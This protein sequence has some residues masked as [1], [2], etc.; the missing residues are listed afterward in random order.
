[1]FVQERQIAL[2]K[3]I[4]KLLYREVQ[5]LVGTS[6]ASSAAPEVCPREAAPVQGSERSSAAAEEL[7][8]TASSLPNL[9]VQRQVGMDRGG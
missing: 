1:M 6:A 8:R 9:G 4:G 2:Y 7:H 5:L 3:I